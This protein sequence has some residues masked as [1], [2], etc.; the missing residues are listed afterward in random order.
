MKNLQYYTDF[1]INNKMTFNG[2]SGHEIL[3]KHLIPIINS[4]ILKTNE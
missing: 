3:I 2:E 1:Y 4:N